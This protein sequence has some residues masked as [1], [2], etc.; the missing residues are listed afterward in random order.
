MVALQTQRRRTLKATVMILQATVTSKGGITIPREIREQLE[1]HA[2]DTITFI[3]DE[4]NR[5]TLEKPKYR[6][7]ASLAGAA[8]SLERPMSTKEM[9]EI[10]REDGLVEP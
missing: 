4:E 9:L 1:L 5:V 2:G 10:A 8:G 7:M 6:S 3:V